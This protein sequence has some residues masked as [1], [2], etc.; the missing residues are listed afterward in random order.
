MIARCVAAKA[1]SSRRT[2]E[3]RGKA[4]PQLGIRSATRSEPARRVPG[5]GRTERPALGMVFAAMLAERTDY[6]TAPGLSARNR[7]A[8]TGPSGWSCE[9][10]RR[11]GRAPLPTPRQ[12]VPR[13]GEIRA[14]EQV[15]RPVVVEVVS[16]AEGAPSCSRWEAPVWKGAVSCYGPNL[17][18]LGRGSRLSYGSGAS[19]DIMRASKNAP[20][21]W[22]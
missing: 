17:G 22:A 8:P 15:G 10:P 14:L 2:S 20:P 16:D 4:G 9:A 21:A 3:M 12:E 19:R 18:A 13:W 5:A 6:D 7:T 1:G 11:R